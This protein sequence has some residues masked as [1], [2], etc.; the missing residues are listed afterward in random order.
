MQPSNHQ[1]LEI[2]LEDAYNGGASLKMKNNSITLFQCEIIIKKIIYAIT[3]KSKNN[4]KL[5]T[6]LNCVMNNQLGNSLLSISLK[7]SN[8]VELNDGDIKIKYIK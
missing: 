3:Y 6:I 7:S 2:Y 1:F 5:T 4:Q 8:C